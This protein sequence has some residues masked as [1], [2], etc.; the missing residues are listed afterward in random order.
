MS[1]TSMREKPLS[2][3]VDSSVLHRK[4]RRLDMATRS[5]GEALASLSPQSGRRV[6]GSQVQVQAVGFGELSPCSHV[7]VIS[8]L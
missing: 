4:G 2:H 5:C 3:N 7:R 1:K 6:D 8:L